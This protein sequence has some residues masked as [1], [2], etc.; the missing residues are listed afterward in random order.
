MGSTNLACRHC[1]TALNLLEMRAVNAAN[2]T[3]DALFRCPYCSSGYYPEIG[4]LHSLRGDGQIAQ[5]YFGMPLSLGGTQKRDLNHVDVG[6]HRPVQMHSLEPGY[7]YDTLYLLGGHRKG[8]DE[9]NWL[10]FELAGAQNRATLGEDAL[11]S[12]LRTG[13][14]EVAI[15]ATLREDRPSNFPIDFGDSLEIVYA[16]T[17]QLGE[18]TNPPWIDLLQEAQEAIRQ[19]NTLAAL[20]IL[21]SAVDNYLIRQ[22]Y[23]YLIWE[24]HDGDSARQW[25]NDLEDDYDPNRLTIAKYGL[26]QVTGTRLTNGSYA[27]LWSNF[28]QIVEERDTIIRSE[29]S[30]V[31]TAPDQSTAVEFF[32]TTVSLLVAAYD[33]FGLY[34]S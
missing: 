11:I 12:L 7:E 28:S 20:P 24:G 15:S 21:R 33:L 22:M 23:L 5:E 14:T 9:E 13:A 30:S 25:I 1:D 2:I 29:T 27:N 19:E 16:A 8:I 34:S 10:S 4:L 6:E 26:E 31:L 17:T 18:V 32:N 3:P